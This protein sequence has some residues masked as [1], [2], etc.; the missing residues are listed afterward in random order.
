MVIKKAGMVLGIS[1]LVI[2]CA[3][4]KPS[5]ASAI[6]E[7]IIAPAY[8]LLAGQTAVLVQAS[9]TACTDAMINQKELKNL[10]HAWLVSMSAWEQAQIF[11]FGPIESPG[12][13]NQYQY[14]P[15]THNDIGN[16]VKALLAREQPLTAADI[17]HAA[18]PAQGLSA[19]EY[20]LFDKENTPE[21]FGAMGIAAQ[22]RCFYLQYSSKKLADVSASMSKEWSYDGSY[23]QFFYASAKNKAE[24]HPMALVLHS[25]VAELERI[26]TDKIAFPL[27]LQAEKKRVNLYASEAWRSQKSLALIRSNLFV[28]GK[29]LDA[30]NTGLLSILESEG[31]NAL[32]VK[33]IRQQIHEVNAALQRLDI[34]FNEALKSENGIVALNHLHDAVEALLLT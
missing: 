19:L 26:K 30:H 28:L 2:S 9:A 22:Q 24:Q 13:R 15:D 34:H 23:R 5:F 14:W 27:G 33:K 10:R 6:S 17:E 31:S 8:Q 7:K 1:L 18:I 32:L 29:L 3:G 4:E 25:I 20:V 11:R 16:A 12:M 21:L